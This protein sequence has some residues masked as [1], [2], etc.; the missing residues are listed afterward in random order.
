MINIPSGINIGGPPLE[1]DARPRSNV[2]KVSD[3]ACTE[4][5]LFRDQLGP[6]SCLR[7]VL[8]YVHLHNG[9]PFSRLCLGSTL[10]A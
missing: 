7:L 2:E 1:P 9:R 5:D 3:T 8:A 4:P 10:S 6:R